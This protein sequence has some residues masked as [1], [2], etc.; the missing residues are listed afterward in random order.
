MPTQLFYEM[1]KSFSL[2]K[3]FTSLLKFVC[4]KQGQIFA[5]MSAA[6]HF[7]DSPKGNFATA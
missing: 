5:V 2:E 6:S 3:L 1:V 7:K 4:K